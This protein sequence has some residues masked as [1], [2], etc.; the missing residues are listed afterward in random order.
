MRKS[1]LTDKQIEKLNKGK[2]VIHGCGKKYIKYR[3]LCF[4]HR[5]QEYKRRNPLRY[6]YT[7]LRSNAKRRGKEFFI[8]FDYFKDFCIKTKILLGRG[9]KADSYHIDRINEDKGY[10]EG[11]L[12]VLTNIENLKKYR[13]YDY[14]T[15]KGTTSIRLNNN[16]YSDVPF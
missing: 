4:H 2:C 14:M 12:Q 3:Y 15:N 5:T 7:N 16:D 10:I 1:E 9:I 8:S 11:N 13:E 6:A